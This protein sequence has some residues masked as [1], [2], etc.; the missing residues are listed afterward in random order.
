M[1]II[2]NKFLKDIPENSFNS[3]VITK[4]NSGGSGNP[5][6][7]VPTQASDFTSPDPANANKIWEIQSNIDLADGNFTAPANI[8]L[9][10]IGG[11]LLNIGNFVGNNTSFNFLVKG[12]LLGYIDLFSATVSGTFKVDKIFASAFGA[13]DDNLEST[14]NFN[15]GKQ[16]LFLVNQNGGHLVWDKYNTG[17]FWASVKWDNDYGSPIFPNNPNR[18]NV[19]TIG[20]GN[21]GVTVEHEN[22]VEIITISNNL[23]TSKRY[24]FYNS[25]NS[26]IVGGMIRGDRYRHYYDQSLFINTA[27]TSAGSVNLIITETDERNSTT[28]LKTINI[29][30]PLT[31]SSLATNVQEITDF[32]NTEPQLSDYTATN[33]GQVTEDIH[34]STV[35]LRYEV[36]LRGPQGMDYLLDFADVDSGAGIEKNWSPYE[37]GHGIMFGSNTLFCGFERIHITE[38]HGDGSGSNLQGNGQS[39][40]LF[41]DLTQ[42]FIDENGTIDGGNTDYYYSDKRAL[43][44]QHKHF[45]FASNAQAATDL[46]NWKY[47]MVYYD[48]AGVFLEK[49]PPL[50]PYETYTPRKNVVEYR[51]MVED[52][53]TD[54]NNFYYFINSRSLSIGAF[55]RDVEIS[56]CRRHGIANPPIEFVLENFIIRDIGG[57][58]PQFGLNL[59]D[60]HK[61]NRGWRIING[62]FQN[63]AN[64]DIIIKGASQGVISGI[65]FKQN[66]YNLRGEQ[67][68]RG[69]AIDTGYGRNITIHSCFFEHK[70]VNLDIGTQ[71]HN[72]DMFYGDINCHYGG[73]IVKNNTLTNVSINGGGRIGSTDS[74]SGGGNALN[75][76]IGNTRKF[77]DGWGN[78]RMDDDYNSFIKRDN[79]TIMNDKSSQQDT[80]ADNSIRD[81]LIRGSVEDYI[82]SDRTLLDAPEFK[83]WSKGEYYTG[84][85]ANPGNRHDVALTQYVSNIDGL[86]VDFGLKFEKGVPDSYTIKN[87]KARSLWIEDCQYGTD[88]VGTFETLSFENDEFTMVERIS[89]NEGY[90]DNS[91]FG[92]PSRQNFLRAD[93]DTNIN[94]HFKKCRF[95]SLDVTVGLFMYLGVRGTITFEDCYFEHP[96][97]ETIDLSASGNAKTIGTYVG[98]N[99]GIIKFIDCEFNNITVDTT[100]TSHKI[101][102]TKS[103]P[104]LEVYAD[105]TAALA[106]GIPVG[107]MYRTATGEPRITI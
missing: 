55:M 62:T 97:G 100:G 11:S 41:A 36:S 54:I 24:Q 86:E 20:D 64:G 98:A 107:Y 99:V 80:L 15:V 6:I 57:Q 3:S 12:K 51:V 29:N 1:A 94:L 103:S 70:E 65:Y 17:K 75:Y 14:D 23:I 58:E 13:I 91:L 106:G 2:D 93:A 83:G 34:R 4:L 19:W 7:F 30:I 22:N 89:A 95:V 5:D 35:S 77:T 47:Y 87:T 82:R 43:P 96:T 46:K 39:P 18:D 66:S 28:T 31:L 73:V 10:C 48:N 74:E 90:L 68:D 104:N 79:I 8:V 53:G 9:R 52:N 69:L 21:D 88:G 92:T 25:R 61:H 16:L 76:L 32:I 78:K 44:S 33:R 60:L 40:I 84:F 37:W 49:S 42:G 102:Y 63:C 101:L 45:S 50:L 27:A 71:F 72:N 67:D 56:Y 26:R 85:L 81:I 105:N 59:E 38:F